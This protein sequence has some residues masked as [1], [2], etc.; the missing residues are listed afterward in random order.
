MTDKLPRITA[1]KLIPILEK[2]GFTLV[3]QSGSHKIYRNAENVRLTVP[4]HSGEILHPKI[5]K[6]II[7]DANLSFDELK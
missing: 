6:Q 3:R 2:K 5:L 7:N 1:D 4:Y